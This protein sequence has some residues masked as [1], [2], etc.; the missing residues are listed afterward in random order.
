MFFSSVLPMTK[1]ALMSFE[2]HHLI[3]HL[4]QGERSTMSLSSLTQ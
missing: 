2:L 1:Q 3:G 4:G